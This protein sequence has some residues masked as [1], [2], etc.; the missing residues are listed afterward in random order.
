MAS[1]VFYPNPTV[2]ETSGSVGVKGKPRLHSETLSQK[3][4]KQNHKQYFKRRI[5][6]K[7]CHKETGGL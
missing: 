2:E 7:E 3:R 5:D 1:H 6:A 4:N